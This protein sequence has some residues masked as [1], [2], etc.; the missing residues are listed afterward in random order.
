M[1]DK[2]ILMLERCYY[3]VCEGCPFKDKSDTE[4]LRKLTQ[5]LYP[6]VNRLQDEND[7][8]RKVADEKFGMSVEDVVKEERAREAVEV[9]AEIEEYICKL[10]NKYRR[11][12]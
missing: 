8:L 2:A 7:R 5:A 1:A 12:K 10:E 4:C 11:K 9:L 6:V 3:E